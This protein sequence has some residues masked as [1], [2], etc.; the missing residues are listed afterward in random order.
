MIA[1]AR[2]KVTLDDLEPRVLRCIEVPLGVKL[3]R[4]HLTLQVALGWTNSHLYEFRAG[5]A[6]WGLP[7]PW[8]DGPLDARMATLLDI[9]E[10]TGVKT[11]HYLY[12][13]GDGWEHTIKLERLVDPEP[14][15]LYPR[16]IEASGRCPPE[17]VGGSWGYAE[18]LEVIGDK[19]QERHAEIRKWLGNEFS[20]KV[21]DPERLK[22]DV[23][24]L[25]KRWSRKPA[26]KKSRSA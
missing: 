19:T 22:G 1:I 5:G 18:M 7:D 10:N 6:G 13:F 16:F 26:V 12:D 17:D 9:I 4:L 3:D 20:P 21:V 8:P 15:A 24:T 14:G 2:L 25:A 23:A 11:L